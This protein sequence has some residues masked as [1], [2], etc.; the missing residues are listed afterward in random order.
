MIS[1]DAESNEIIINP[2]LNYSERYFIPDEET[3]STV[4]G[5]GR[6]GE[7]FILIFEVAKI[8]AKKILQQSL[9]LLFSIAIIVSM[10]T[11]NF[12]VTTF[13]IHISCRS[14]NIPTSLM[15]RLNRMR[16]QNQQIDNDFKKKIKN[17]AYLLLTF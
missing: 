14:F 11:I 3:E 10:I 2:D 7:T 17:N 4:W 6:L 8:A 15:E 13:M 1:F 16:T 9:I 12:F 5:P